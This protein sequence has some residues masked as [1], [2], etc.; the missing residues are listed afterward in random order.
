MS[1]QDGNSPHFKEAFSFDE[2]GLFMGTCRAWASPLEP[3]KFILPA[4]A[5]FDAPKPRKGQ[6]PIWSGTEWEYV[7]AKRKR[8]WRADGSHVDVIDHP[9]FHP[10]EGHSETEPEH[11]A[12]QKQI[13]DLN[14]DIADEVRLLDALR[15]RAVQAMMEQI[16][17]P[18]EREAM[19][20]VQ[21]TMKKIEKLTEKMK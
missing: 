11:I 3:G 13:A 1:R 7:P 16:A 5:T 9:S 17:T 10:D 19:K 15:A 21:K 12:L 4:M 18:E 8:F 6:I 20:V 14:E 2:R